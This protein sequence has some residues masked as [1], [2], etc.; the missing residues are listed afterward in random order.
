[1]DG[2]SRKRNVI[3]RFAAKIQASGAGP[4]A[5]TNISL[6]KQLIR[7]TAERLWG[8]ILQQ[9]LYASKHA[10]RALTPCLHSPLEIAISERYYY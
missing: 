10:L 4:K 7:S 6:Y 2:D 5:V 1:M 9:A 8:V 3:S